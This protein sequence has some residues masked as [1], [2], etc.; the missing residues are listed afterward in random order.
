MLSAV[1][2]RRCWSPLV[3]A[4]ALLAVCLVEPCWPGTQ[5]DTAKPRAKFTLGRDTTFFTE[6][7]DNDGY[8]DYASALNAYFGKGVKVE[9]NAYVP[10]ISFLGPA[11]EGA[12]PL[13]NIFF[14]ALGI[15]PLPVEGDYFL[16]IVRYLTQVKNVGQ[17]PALRA[18]DQLLR[19]RFYPWQADDYPLVALWLVHYQ[20]RLDRLKQEMQRPRYFRPLIPSERLYEQP[21]PDVPMFR[22]LSQA[23]L[24][25][26]MLRT[27][28][29]LYQ[30]AWD[31]LLASKRLGQLVGQG[32]T[33]IE[34]LGG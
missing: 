6:P 9:E 28:H 29:G 16:P 12:V 24:A 26:A 27:K 5:K 18:E 13:P 1:C 34:A 2:S 21:L 32:S 22:S 20:A 11:P 19:A 17:Q 15:A 25:Q 33:L 7:L 8:V 23:Y 14:Q 31:D 10:L 3:V 30:Q 4:L